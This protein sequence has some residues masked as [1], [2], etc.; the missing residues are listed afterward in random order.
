MQLALKT[1][2]LISEI[3]VTNG[4]AGP[5]SSV[6]RVINTGAL[7]LDVKRRSYRFDLF[8]RHYLDGRADLVHWNELGMKKVLEYLLGN[9]PV[10]SS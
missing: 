7:F 6:I 8:H 1:V 3:L 4:V 9:L 2:Y 5:G 10:I